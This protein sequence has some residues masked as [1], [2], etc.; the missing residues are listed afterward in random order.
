MGNTNNSYRIRTDVGKDK[1]ITVN[2]DSEYDTLEILSLKINQRGQYRYHTSNYGVVVGRVLANNGFGVPNAKLSLFIA[3]DEN[4]S[5]IEN[6]IYPY[7]T[8]GSKNSDGIRYNLLPSNQKDDCHQV[9]GTFPSKRMMLDDGSVLEVFDKYYHYTTRTNESGDYM[10]F[11]IPTGTYNLHMDLDISDCGKLS[12]RPR[13]FLYKG[14]NIDQFENPNQ[15]KIDTELSALAQ[16]F[17]QDTTIDVKPF[18]GDENEGTNIGITREDININYKFEPTCVFMGSI[19]SDTPDDGISKRCVPSNKMGDMR[20]LVTGSGTIEIIRKKIDNTVEELQIKGKQL[21]N[22]NG[23][24]CFQIPMNLD[25]VMTDEYGNLVPTD[26]PEK[27]IPTRCEVR[28][29]MSMDGNQTES[30]PYK[31]GKVLVPHNPLESGELD[32]EFGSKTKDVS[33]KSLMWNGV[34]TVKSFIPRFQKSRNIKTNRFSGI[35]NVNI[36]GGNSPIPYNNIRIKIPFMFWLLCNVAKLFI[37]IVQV[38][39]NLKVALMT[40]GLQLVNLPYTYISSELCPDLEYWYFAPGMNTAG[41]SNTAL[42]RFWKWLTGEDNK[43]KKWQHESVC[44]TFKSIANDIK[45]EEG[46]RETVVFCQYM[47]P[48]GPPKGKP[49]V[50]SEEEW[51]TLTNNANG[52]CQTAEEAEKNKPKFTDE[53]TKGSN[54]VKITDNIEGNFSKDEMSVDV[55]NAL[56][57]INPRVKLTPDVDYLMQCVEMNLAQEYE[58]IKFDFYNDWLNGVIYLPRW[59]RD[60]KY[61]RRRKNGKKVVIEKVKGCINDVKRSRVS[62]RYVQQCSLSYND[63]MKV[64]TYTGCRG[65]NKLRCHKKDGMDYVSVFGKYSGI[66]QEQ[67]TILGDNV[68]YMKPNEENKLLFATD[69]VMLG[70]LFD[71]DENGIPSTF[72]SLP[73]T[74]YKMPTNMALTNVDDDSYSYVDENKDS[75]DD[76]HTSV[77]TLSD[78]NS[79]SCGESCVLDKIAEYGATAII[80]SYSE[81]QGMISEYEGITDENVALPYEDVFPV[82][83]MSGI[84]WGYTGPDQ[85][86]PSA[87]K[88][89]AAGGHFMGLSCG[90]AETNI[91]SCV[92]LKRA[93][94]IGTTLSERFEIPI[95]YKDMDDDEEFDVVNYLYVSP[96]GLISKDQINDVTFRSAFATMNQNNLRT[97]VDSVSKHKKYEFDYLIPDSFDGSLSDKLPNDYNSRIALEWDDFWS[98]EAKEKP[99]QYQKIWENEVSLEQGYTVHR[100][101]ETK[102]DDY[103]RF[104]HFY[105]NNNKIM[106]LNNGAMPVYRNSFYFY[107]GLKE[108][109]TA[110]DEFKT[111]FFAPCAKA[112]LV[113][114]ESDFSYVVKRDKNIPFKYDV[115][116]DVKYL[117]VPLSYTLTKSSQSYESNEQ[118]ETPNKTDI[119]ETNFTIE[120]VPIGKYTLLIVDNNGIEVKKEINVGTEEISVNYD[121]K[122]IRHYENYVLGE[123]ISDYVNMTTNGGSIDG[124]FEVIDLVDSENTNYNVRIEHANGSIV[125][126]STDWEVFYSD[127][128]LRLWGA[129][130]YKVYVFVGDYEYLYDEFTIN[131]GV[132]PP[133]IYFGYYKVP[134]TE[135]IDNINSLNDVLSAKFELYKALVSSTVMSA[136]AANTFN[137][138]VGYERGDGASY[139]DIIA[140][141]GEKV[142]RGGVDIATKVTFND[143][144]KNTYALNTTD[145]IAPSD[146]RDSDYHERGK[147]YYTAYNN[148]N[149]VYASEYVEAICNGENTQSIPVNSGDYYVLAYGNQKVLL[150]VENGAVSV[151]VKKIGIPEGKT[152]RIGKLVGLPVFRNPFAYKTVALLTNNSNEFRVDK[153]ISDE[154]YVQCYENELKYQIVEK[155]LR[156]TEYEENKPFVSLRDYEMQEGTIAEMAINYSHNATAGG[157]K[158]KVNFK[159]DGVNDSALKEKERFSFHFVD[160]KTGDKLLFNSNGDFTSTAIEYPWEEENLSGKTMAV[161][162]VNG[163]V[164]ASYQLEIDSI[165]GNP[166]EYWAFWRY[167]EYD[168][169]IKKDDRNFHDYK[170]FNIIKPSTILKIYPQ[171]TFLDGAKLIHGYSGET[172]TL[173]KWNDGNIVKLSESEAKQFTNVNIV[174]DTTKIKSVELLPNE[175]NVYRYGAIFIKTVDKSQE[176]SSTLS[177]EIDL[178][179]SFETIY[180]EQEWGASQ[181]M[182]DVVFCFGGLTHNITLAEGATANTSTYRLVMV[183][184]AND[185]IIKHTL[186]DSDKCTLSLSWKELG[187]INGFEL[188][189]VDN[190]DEQG[191]GLSDNSNGNGG[192]SQEAKTDVTIQYQA[193]VV[194][195]KCNTVKLNVYGKNDNSLKIGIYY[196]SYVYYNDYVVNGESVVELTNPIDNFVN[197][198]LL[199]KVTDGEKYYKVTMNR[200]GAN[201]TNT[202]SA[203]EPDPEPNPDPDDGGDNGETPPE[204]GGENENIEE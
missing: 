125:K 37:R 53:Y 194:D 27:G 159:V 7:T 26:N 161:K 64:T 60:V 11:G 202:P 85:G 151:N 28:F 57:D 86:E 178:G 58:V 13:D 38:I 67:K 115:D 152:I 105:N 191:G 34:Y 141:K 155:K 18:W 195:N 107:F 47:G 119:T 171:Q 186:Y 76:F 126:D 70:T 143:E 15:F 134:Y 122:T 6:A 182:V 118:P 93:C 46:N 185:D 87:D 148:K 94:E 198:N 111:Q 61:K 153:V 114:N 172:F 25:Y 83:E 82:T 72:E 51:K 163:S 89:Y 201:V 130:K 140:G 138:M 19:I 36:H 30:E 49:S 110:I 91:R 179:C 136:D 109:A 117:E 74:T 108:G 200:L 162:S 56:N 124:T 84:E 10:F 187:Q 1:F 52:S 204:N 43:C 197:E 150:P 145:I 180:S 90:N 98:K 106:F 158:N 102:S 95:G 131:N 137:L 41:P 23:V 168:G 63:D 189:I 5:V 193:Q 181:P 88:M 2:L 97:V 45:S 113:G 164:N 59:A 174:N 24:W 50:I 8:V 167:K 173:Y 147:F 132:L 79:L 144:L 3:K 44:K 54:W 32:Y 165:S 166:H 190:Y 203:P 66:V 123:A 77:P 176:A 42:R 156:L 35:K 31:R 9:V 65:N 71:C 154:E 99:E 12:Q 184:K 133:S 160:K 139:V 128:R 169:N 100:V 103:I 81:I 40:I 120:G 183:A 78:I 14:Y 4:A 22:G 68:Y 199:A 170:E 29:R 149:N 33:F 75:E 127:G 96:N 142:A 121:E 21:I 157:D 188:I 16:V 17:T 196:D 48:S 146:Y 192:N 104:R 62:R 129:G 175:E 101:F 80:P 177:A 73:T 112:L 39:N 92:N 69:I 20:D 116:V 135:D 55:K